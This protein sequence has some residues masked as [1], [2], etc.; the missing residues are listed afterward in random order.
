MKNNKLNEFIN[1]AKKELLN[2]G[3]RNPLLKFKLPKARGI[4]FS[5]DAVEIYEKIKDYSNNIEIL[6]LDEKDEKPS[7]QKEIFVYDF[8]DEESGVFFSN[9]NLPLSYASYYI[10]LQSNQDE[11]SVGDSDAQ[12]YCYLSKAM[13]WLNHC[14]NE[15]S[16]IKDH[17]KNI[18]EQATNNGNLETVTTNL[19]SLIENTKDVSNFAAPEFLSSDISKYFFPELTIKSKKKSRS[20]AKPKPGIQ[21][22][23]DFEALSKRLKATTR[24]ARNHIEEKGVNIL[25]LALGS[26]NWAEDNNRE[27][28]RKSP[29]ILIPISISN[30]RGTQKFFFKC[31]EEDLGALDNMTL[32]QKL[33]ADYAIDLP[34][35]NSDEESF[36]LDRY[37]EQV[38]N[39]IDNKVGWSVD[40]NEAVISFF[41][42]NKLVMFEDLDESKWTDEN[43]SWSDLIEIL[44]DP[45]V[46]FKGESAQSMGDEDFVED[47]VESS[48]PTTVI[49]ADSSQIKAILDVRNG[50][51]LVIQGPP[52]T[53]KS[54]TITNIIADSIRQNKTVL[55]VA[56]KMV[57]LEVVSN[58]LKDLGLDALALELHS[59]KGKKK[60]F[61]DD[62]A[63]V[64]EMGKPLKP[65]AFRDHTKMEILNFDELNSISKELNSYMTAVNKKSES[66]WTVREIYGHLLK[67]SQSLENGT[68]PDY[69]EDK[70]SKNSK[71]LIL[72]K[73][74]LEKI[75]YAID[76]LNDHF[77]KMGEPKDHPFFGT[78]LTTLNFT[79]KKSIDSLINNC[80]EEFETLKLNKKNVYEV[81]KNK[82]FLIENL[83]NLHEEYERSPSFSNVNFESIDKFDLSEFIEVQKTFHEL[84]KIKD[85]YKK[86]LSSKA[87]GKNFSKEL[88]ELKKGKNKGGIV[89]F[90]NADLKNAVKSVQGAYKAN[91]EKNIKE[92]IKTIDAIEKTKSLVKKIKLYDTKGALFF[93]SIWASENSDY[94]RLTELASF[95]ADDSMHHKDEIIH[96]QKNKISFANFS[97]LVN[98]L[99]TSITKHEKSLA[100]IKEILK[101]KDSFSLEDIGNKL[102]SLKAALNGDAFEQW[103]SYLRIRKNLDDLRFSWV[104][105]ILEKWRDEDGQVKDWFIVKVMEAHLNIAH[106]EYPVLNSFE[107]AN[108]DNL[109]KKFKELDSLMH[110]ARR[111][112]I[113]ENH[114]QQVS[115][116]AG[117][118][119]GNTGLIKQQINKKRLKLPIRKIMQDAG[120]TIQK[121]K[122]I[123]MMSPLSLASFIKPKSV[124]FDLV[125]FDE[126]SQVPAVD[127]LGAVLRGSQ[128]VVVGD[129]KQMPPTSFFD[130][131]QDTDDEESYYENYK[132]EGAFKDIESILALME[133]QGAPKKLLKWHYRSKYKSLISACNHL[134]YDNRLVLIPA[135]DEKVDGNGFSL[136][137]IPDSSYDRGG[138]RTNQKE[139]QAVAKAVLEHAKNS[140]ELTLGVVAFSLAQRN[141]LEDEIEALSNTNPELSHF[142]TAHGIEK[143][144]VKNLE[145]VQGDQRDVILISIGYGKTKEGFL[146]QSFGPI[147]REG[148]ERRLNVLMSRAKI[149]MVI[150]SNFKSDD[151]KSNP[152]VL[153]IQH[154]KHF[155]K[156]AE[157]GI[158]DIPTLEGGDFDSEFE[159]QVHD[160][161]VQRGYEI[162]I[163][164]GSAGFLIDLAVKHSK[165]EGAYS[166]A[167]ECDGAAYHSSYSARER[168]ILR[169][170]VLEDRGWVFHRIWSTQW[171]KNPDAE[172]EKVIEAIDQAE[173]ESIQPIQTKEENIIERADSKIIDFDV[174]KYK[175]PDWVIP[176]ETHPIRFMGSKDYSSLYSYYFSE[177]DDV[178]N[179]LYEL[180][181]IE[182]PINLELIIRRLRM[183]LDLGSAGSKFEKF[184]KE[185]LKSEFYVN[186]VGQGDKK[187][188]YK[189][190]IAYF[191]LNSEDFPSTVRSREALPAAERDFK[192][193]PFIEVY[194]AIKK[195]TQGT[196]GVDWAELSKV[197]AKDFGYKQC[198]QNMVEY[199]KKAYSLY[200]K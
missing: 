21:T 187:F 48:E 42:F 3:T 100:P 151:I 177:N 125:I 172:I 173:S 150:F 62:L 138:T 116:A 108:Y 149:K 13:F 66:G 188:F 76:A 32:R 184:V 159:R 29:L 61:Y 105:D 120:D 130:S 2:L 33:N 30:D 182:G 170:A 23:Y 59:N 85:K 96:L 110:Q 178:I 153:G 63:K 83:K 156:Y 36:S 31:E 140:P 53:G 163:Q 45:Q 176:Y 148:G 122:P 88:V 26:L 99:N 179:Y 68:F 123:F 97:K 75:I 35:F 73:D 14:D 37:F 1:K 152:K 72:N 160:K 155:M 107:L 168:D 118:T 186:R 67:A 56:E 193:I 22:N 132:E 161:L 195:R 93:T 162:D 185:H 81:L 117:G 41:N 136:K 51:N 198:S 147:N 197:I 27:D 44:L 82:E 126:A 43:N 94:S 115:Q 65:K 77:K 28:I 106:E 146:S 154:L 92:L 181:S 6:P 143:L 15:D 90:F 175:E 38:E 70:E 86:V 196:S 121:L 109:W 129:S 157:T 191:G 113:M 145:S 10:Y 199:F 17:V 79:D 142:V 180:V 4:E 20:A 174:K 84:I 69:L 134:S 164:V 25:Y 158:Q 112:E 190:N 8:G 87:W 60:E 131:V 16:D 34:A 50:K 47:F 200:K 74:E 135:A 103:A 141:C 58:K 9:K 95:F 127:A 128:L 133:S 139:A 104:V 98:A 165:K 57:A 167:I 5:D 119:L 166:L 12:N 102:P 171:F 71:S 39:L 91:P 11:V 7:K 169:Q 19:A 78:G 46:Q 192:F 40:R 101:Y 114:Y 80:I 137:Y 55:F 64:M 24:D 111:Y 18:K 124:H 54:Q 52:G 189:N 194:V 89:N 49:D 183:A 144:F